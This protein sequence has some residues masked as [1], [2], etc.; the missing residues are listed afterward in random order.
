MAIKAV[1]DTASLNRLVL[2]LLVFGT[3][4]RLTNLD[5]PSLSVRQKATA[6]QKATREL[7]KIQAARQLKD[8]LRERNSLQIERLYNLAIRSQVLVQRIYDKA[9]Q[10]PF[11]LLLVQNETAVVEVNQRFTSFRITV[12]KLYL[13]EDS[14]TTTIPTTLQ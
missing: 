8:A 3:Y 1:N 4:S 9:Q 5:P 13:A 7:A 6:I 14:K 11:K 12:V 2:T 10:R